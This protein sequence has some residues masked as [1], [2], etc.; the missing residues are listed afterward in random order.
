VYPAIP[1]SSVW[2]EGVP[3]WDAVAKYSNKPL[4]DQFVTISEELCPEIPEHLPD[5]P[6]N[7]QPAP[8]LEEDPVKRFDQL[9]ERL[10]Q[11]ETHLKSEIITSLSAGILIAAGYVPPR[12][13]GRQPVRINSDCWDRGKVDWTR[14]RLWVDG[15]R[16]DDIRVIRSPVAETAEAISSISPP[17]PPRPPGRPTRAEEIWT[18]YINLRDTG[19]INFGLSFRANVPTI[20]ECVLTLSED[21]SDKRGLDGEVIRRV[22]GTQFK[23]DKAAQKDSV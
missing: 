9:S 20:R 8:Q 14:S 22:V 7:W 10:T 17:S 15:N 2:Q 23:L 12:V 6:I 3:L 11:L 19:K 18:A 16:F 1:A 21:P 5:E 4:W 13:R